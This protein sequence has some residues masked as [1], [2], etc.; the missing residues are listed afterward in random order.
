MAR[1]L[2]EVDTGEGGSQGEHGAI[3]KFKLNVMQTAGGSKHYRKVGDK[4]K[5]EDSDS[6]VNASPELPK[7]QPVTNT[8]KDKGRRHLHGNKPNKTNKSSLR[9]SQENEERRP[10]LGK[11]FNL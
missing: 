5:R 11:H 7:S 6:S 1:E 9:K 8:E 4:S 10:S 3:P 2:L